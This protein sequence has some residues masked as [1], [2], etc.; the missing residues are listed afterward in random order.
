MYLTIQLALFSLVAKSPYRSQ[1]K[2]AILKRFKLITQ[3]HEQ[4]TVTDLFVDVSSSLRQPHQ[5][6][7]VSS[8]RCAVCWGVL[9]VT[10]C[11]VHLTPHLHQMHKALQLHP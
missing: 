11:G 7:G 2:I 8:N 4:L 6:V 10:G 5:A 9:E 1:I 3:H